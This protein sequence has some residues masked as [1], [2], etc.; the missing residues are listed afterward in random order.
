[1]NSIKYFDI[2]ETI[3]HKTA[4]SDEEKNNLIEKLNVFNNLENDYEFTSQ[5]I[6]KIEADET[7]THFIKN[8]SNNAL[9]PSNQ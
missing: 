1:M 3:A 5:Q 9:T 4:L 7:N 6:F 8:N 2:A